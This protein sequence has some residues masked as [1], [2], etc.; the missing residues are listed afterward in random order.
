MSCQH[1]NFR[2][3]TSID[4]MA[5]DGGAP[6]H[7]RLFIREIVCE[8]CQLRFYLSNSQQGESGFP[9]SASQQ[10]P[11]PVYQQT[12]PTPNP[13]VQEQGNIFGSIK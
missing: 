5:P 10:L 9:I 2:V 7:F 6:T 12:P 13:V 11:Q 1:S 8:Q 4:R 3:Q